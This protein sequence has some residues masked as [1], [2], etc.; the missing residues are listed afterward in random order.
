VDPLEVENRIEAFVSACFRINATDPNF[1]R[2]VDLFEGGYI[3][4]I[5]VV[6]LLAF[7]REEFGVEI[8]EKAL[9][10]DEFSR[11]DGIAQVVSRLTDR[12]S[13]ITKNDTLSD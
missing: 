3:D 4:S 1:N 11:I 10:S 2:G 5:G 8:P 12:S 7:I 6:E 9:L 13:T